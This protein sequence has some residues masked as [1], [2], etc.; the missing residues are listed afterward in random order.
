MLTK[1]FNYIFKP[2]GLQEFIAAN[3]P[4]DM[5]DVQRLEYIWNHYKHQRTIW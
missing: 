1:L 3:N 4:R 5:A 2:C